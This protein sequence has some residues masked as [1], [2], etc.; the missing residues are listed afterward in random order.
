MDASGY[1]AGKLEGRQTADVVVIGAGIAGLSVAFELAS[2]ALSVI[3]LDRGPIATG[4]SARTTAHLASAWDDGFDHLISKRGEENGRRCFESHAA[5]IDRI[6][7]ICRA[8][9]IACDFARLDGFLF[10]P[11]DDGVRLL[12]KEFEACNKIGFPGV[13]WAEAQPLSGEW[14]RALRFPD[15]GRFHPV[16]YM[17]GLARRIEQLK[18]RLFADTVVKEVKE[19]RG[20]VE[21]VAESG[22][23]SAP[24][25]VVATNSPINDRTAIHTKQAPYRTYAIA[26]KIDRGTVPDALFWD[27]LD[28]YHYVRFQPGEQSDLI[29]IGGEDHKSAEAN[30]G[31]ARVR[32]LETWARDYFPQM[33]EV[34]HRWSGQV[35]EPIDGVAFIG[36]NPGSECVFVV[37]GD[38]G[39]GM[40]HGVL[41]GLLIGDMIRGHENE[42]SELY[43]PDRAMPKSPL[44]YV[45]ENL[46]ALKGLGE[47]LMPGEVDSV[48]EIKPGEGAIIRDGLKKI[49]A[50]R[51]EDGT[52]YRKSA[53]CTHLGCQLQWNSFERC[54]DCACHGS[55]FAGDGSVLNAPAISPLEDVEAAKAEKDA[56]AEA[57]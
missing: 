9:S 34:T 48:D 57:K 30:D 31:E 49:A 40:T 52:L 42:W 47:F 54:W 4:V 2:K 39:Q 19:E 17:V 10:A 46:T 37:T 5:A 27:T 32:R 25:A 1:R 12:E 29:V 8:E 43:E 44:T 33:G 53:A 45:S 15:Q 13:H 11:D 23:V 16:K 24:F 14:K 51:D 36:L 7:E 55:H 26:A 20:A 50:F 21:V 18:G 6:E 22:S 38:S 41:A 56:T 3:V 28:P 35:Q